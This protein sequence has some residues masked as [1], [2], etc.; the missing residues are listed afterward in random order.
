MTRELLTRLYATGKYE[1]AELGTNAR[2]E[3]D[4]INY[5]P[6]KIYPVIP[7]MEDKE[8]WGLFN[9]KQEGQFG[10]WCFE[11]TILDFKPDVVLDFRD[12]YHC[13]Y[14]LLS[15]LREYYSHLFMPTVDATPQ[16]DEWANQYTMS[17]GI[18]SYTEFG[19]K[20]LQKTCGDSINFMGVASPGANFEDLKPLNKKEIR[21]KYGLPEDVLIL[22]MV[23]RNQIRKFFPDLFEMFRRFIEVAPRELADKTFLHVHTGHPDAGWDMGRILKEYGLSHKVYFTYICR[24]CADIR[25]HLWNDYGLPCRRC[26][27]KSVFF[28]NPA[29]GLTREG[30]CELYNL[31]DLYI[32]YAGLEGFGVPVVEAAACGI[33]ICTV[34]YSG[35]EDFVEKILAHPVPIGGFS[36]EVQ[37]HRKWAYPNNALF[38]EELIKILN[39][40]LVSW[41]QKTREACKEHFDWDKSAKVWENAIDNLPPAKRKWT[42]PKRDLTELPLSDNL[43]DSAFVKE[44]FKNLSFCE[45]LTKGY[46]Y[47]IFMKNLYNGNIPNSNQNG[48]PQPFSRENVINECR[49]LGNATR[50]WETLRCQ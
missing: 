7:A 42:D 32:Q 39:R 22:G 19:R 49:G 10:A 20:I 30:L 26:G 11:K 24:S 4:R 38:A 33:P 29:F 16:T 14:E 1:I 41:G 46:L 9:S 40:D 36:P 34:P 35:M 3:D 27:N 48:L 12:P 2:P 44:C 45:H 18:L 5:F 25:I 6:W 50:H 13:T 47:H 15:P 43:D 28:T 21:V 37:S 8:S 31:Y 23:A 17:D